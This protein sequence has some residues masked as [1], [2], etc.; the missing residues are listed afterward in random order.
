MIR[1]MFFL[2]VGTPSCSDKQTKNARNMN[3]PSRPIAEIKRLVV[4]KGDSN[5][6]YDLFYAYVDSDKQN[7]D[8]L[9]YSY[10]MAFKYHYPKACMDVFDILCRMYNMDANSINLSR[11][12]DTSRKLALE[13]VKSASELNYLDTKKIYDSLLEKGNN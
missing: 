1:L 7:T 5:A 12:D 8:L 2:L 4:E 3:Q 13:C 6:Y 10:L 9:Y 11:M